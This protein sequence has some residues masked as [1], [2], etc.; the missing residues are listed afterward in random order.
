MCIYT[1]IS[2]YIYIYIY[3]YIPS[4]GG[5]GR[6]S[7]RSIREQGVRRSGIVG[8][9]GA[10]NEPLH[11]NPYEPLYTTTDPYSTITN[12]YSTITNPCTQF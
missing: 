10:H 11:T 12:P 5:I 8:E 7:A 1:C 6:R 9:P 2:V 3:M 4:P